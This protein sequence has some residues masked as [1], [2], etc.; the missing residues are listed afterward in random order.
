MLSDTL[1]QNHLQCCSQLAKT[2]LP[3][4]CPSG[5]LLWAICVRHHVIFF[6]ENAGHVAWC[7]LDK[8]CEVVREY[9][10][11]ITYFMHLLGHFAGHIS[12]SLGLVWAPTLQPQV[13]PCFP[14]CA[15]R[16]L[17]TGLWWEVFVGFAKIVTICHRPQRRGGVITLPLRIKATSAKKKVPK[18]RQGLKTWAPMGSCSIGHH[19]TSSLEDIDPSLE[20]TCL[21]PL[22]HHWC[23]SRSACRS[24][25]STLKAMM[26]G[27]DAMVCNSVRG[28]ESLL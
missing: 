2:S 15:S 11:N 23:K 5:Q 19:Q 3:S 13:H 4:G 14:S 10:Q 22:V 12:R 9:P 18:T 24:R 6:V 28:P 21:A 20:V 25:F 26:S 27:S 8:T 16:C 17:E 7:Y 1:G